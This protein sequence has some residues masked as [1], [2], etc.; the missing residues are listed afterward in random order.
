LI[1]WDRTRRVGTCVIEAQARRDY[2]EWAEDE[3]RL[4]ADYNGQFGIDAAEYAAAMARADT[5]E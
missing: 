3:H 1:R 4:W 5:A 2:R